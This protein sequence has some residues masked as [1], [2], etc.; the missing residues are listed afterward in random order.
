V[1]EELTLSAY[2][3]DLFYG[4]M[5]SKGEADFIGNMTS[6]MRSFEVVS[7]NI[8]N[9]PASEFVV[10]GQE[11]PDLFRS[12]HLSKITITSGEREARTILESIRNGTTTFED[13]AR[14][15]SQDGF[16]DRGGDMG[17]RYSYE[18]ESEIPNFRDREIVLNLNRGEMSHVIQVD[19]RWVFYRVEDELKQPDFEDEAVMD[20]VKSY[21][22]YY[23]RGRMEDWAIS[24]A[25]D[26]IADVGTLGMDT[27]AAR[28]NLEKAGFG[29]IPINYGGVE[30]FTPVE[31]FMIPG[32]SE[33]DV[34]SLSTDE[35]FWK[36]AFST[37]MNTPSEPM[38]HL[39]NVLVFFPIEETDVSDSI[40]L[41][42]ASTYS[43]YWVNNITRQSL[44]YYFTSNPRMNDMFGDA[45]FRYIAP[46]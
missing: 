7:F 44:H 13:A 4:T 22:R 32:L 38:V 27:A 23:D 20:R 29:P 42:I 11:N 40:S 2:Y 5:I 26:F 45:F 34:R 12:I 24:Q 46:Q 18:L 16:A 3:D 30:L 21:Y 33:D 28:W 25:R 14:A 36:V 10:Y 9:F 8:D 37:Q 43:S 31:S 17:I 41:N 19:D 6:K 15:Q 1:Q 35:N 39:N